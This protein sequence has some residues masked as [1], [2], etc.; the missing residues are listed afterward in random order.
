MHEISHILRTKFHEPNVGTDH[1]HRIRLI[2]KLQNNYQ[3]NALVLVSAPAG[4]GKSYLV[5]CWLTSC[6]IPFAWITLDEND[7]DLRTFLEYLTL[8]NKDLFEGKLGK[9]LKLLEA[10]ELPP[11]PVI[12]NTLIN[13]LDTVEKEFVLVL[14]DYHNVKDEKIH[15]L[16]NSLLQYPPENMLVCIITRKDPPIKIGSLRAYDRMNEI[17]TK[18]L[19]FNTEEINALYKNMLGLNIDEDVSNILLERTEGWV[20]GLRLTALSVNSL[21]ELKTLLKKMRLDNR[22]VTEY[23]IEEVLNMQ[24]EKFQKYLIKTSILD[25]FCAELIEEMD[26]TKDTGKIDQISGEEFIEWLENTNLF[27]ISIDNEHRWFR[28]HHE[29]QRLLQKL[30][31]KKTSPDK[32]KV[33]HKK[34]GSWYETNGFVEEAIKH[35]LEAGEPECA[36][37]IVENNSYELL[38]SDQYRILDEWLKLI[39]GEI[40]ERRYKLQ[41]LIAWIEK[42]RFHFPELLDALEKSKEFL[43]KG[44]NEHVYAS[45][46]YWLMSFVKIFLEGDVTGSLNYAHKGLRLILND[47][48]GV[49]RGEIELQEG[50]TMH[51]AGK[52]SEALKKVRESSSGCREKGRYWERLQFGLS[53]INMLNGLLENSYEEANILNEFCVQ[54]GNLFA[55]A[56]SKWFLGTASLHMFNLEK[57]EQHFKRLLELRFITFDRAAIDGLIGLAITYQ[58]IGDN[59]KVYETLQVAEEYT[60]WS[61]EPTHILLLDSGKARINLLRGNISEAKQWQSALNIEP[62]IPSMVFFLCDPYITECRVLLTDGTKSSMNLASR[63]LEKLYK[64]TKEYH[65]VGQTIEILVLLSIVQNEL[66]HNNKAQETMKSALELAIPGKWIRPFMEAGINATILLNQLNKQ[67]IYSEYCTMLI[68]K[69]DNHEKMLFTHTTTFDGETESLSEPLTQ[70]EIEILVLLSHG[71]KNREIGDKIFLAPTTVKKHIYNIYQ[72]FNVHSRI[73]VISKAKEYELI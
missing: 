43:E 53:A 11:F 59:N 17:R 13:E 2:E 56:W 51:M 25:K 50:M 19:S 9:T 16:I 48:K 3:K 7:N 66:G 60:R 72:K 30:L 4:Y 63:K 10:I 21:D 31:K 64:S 22:L 14:D 8:S 69:F 28:Y 5:S 55:E 52:N 67:N 26:V 36:A 20:T 44:K 27:V 18:D 65:L 62:H 23:L 32:I 54:N 12:A 34:I 42:Q 29:F 58:L 46:W 38:N 15:S 49:L 57:A 40:K 24:P 35:L 61:K 6:K 68:E 47:V 45:E 70:R 71:L 39:P 1:V 33:L 73:E 41:I 37:E